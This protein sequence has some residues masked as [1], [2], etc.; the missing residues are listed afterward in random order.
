MRL[1]SKNKVKLATC[2]AGAGLFR[3]LAVLCFNALSPAVS[4]GFD[5]PEPNQVASANSRRLSVSSAWLS[6]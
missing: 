2:R 5:P 3:L 4:F 1:R 6:R